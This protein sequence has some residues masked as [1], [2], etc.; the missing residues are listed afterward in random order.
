MNIKEVG[1]VFVDSLK[2]VVIELEENDDG[3]LESLNSEN[4]VTDFLREKF[5]D[6]I[7]FLPKGHNRDF[8]DITIVLNGKEYHINVKMVGEGNSYNAG[9]PKLFNY[10]L[11][12]ETAPHWKTI[13]KSVL[14]E[15]PTTIKN[16]YYYFT[17]YKKSDK[18]PQFFGLT[19]VHEDS[20]VT[21]PS[22]P[23]QFK[24]NLNTT[25]R[26]KKEKCSFILKLFK[27]VLRKKAEPYLLLEGIE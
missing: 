8:G 4:N 1:K 26:T 9:G 2:D 21:N 27:D 3:R 13:V 5:A 16:D 6:Q 10:I 17:V 15:K 22:N 20:V 24:Y 25:P 19:E 18:T 23:I 14:E 12:D 7:T 11:F